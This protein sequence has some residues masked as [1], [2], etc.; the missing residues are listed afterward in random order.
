M[1]S[2]TVAGDA[3]AAG[4]IAGMI[5]TYGSPQPSTARVFTIYVNPICSADGNQFTIHEYQFLGMLPGDL[6][7]LRFVH[8]GKPFGDIFFHHVRSA[9]QLYHSREGACAAVS[10]ALQLKWKALHTQIMRLIESSA[11]V[12]PQVEDIA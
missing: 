2:D 5:E 11:A 7:A 3:E 1:E 8:G 4:A 9:G 6:A 10:E 12:V